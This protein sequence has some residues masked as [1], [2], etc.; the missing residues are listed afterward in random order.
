MARLTI[1]QM[2]ESYNTYSVRYTTVHLLGLMT[3]IYL[4]SDNS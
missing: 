2:T 1:N 3:T 4:K